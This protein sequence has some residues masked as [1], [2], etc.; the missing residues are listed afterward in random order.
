M[1][2][3]GF[4]THCCDIVD[5]QDDRFFEVISMADCLEHMPYPKKGLEAARQLIIRG[6]ILFLSMPNMSAPLWG[7]LHQTNANPYWQE[8]EHYH[9]FS[10]ERLFD[11]LRETR[12]S[13]IGYGV[14]KRY[15]CCM[16]VIARA[17]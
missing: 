1:N 15:R 8:I 5:Y 2:A 10:R 16:E 9:N 17:S 6:G 4:Q 11:L 12:F 13:P 7:Y 14:S 3:V